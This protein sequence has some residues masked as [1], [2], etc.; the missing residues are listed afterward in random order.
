MLGVLRRV[1][2]RKQ[3]LG[4]SDFLVGCVCNTHR[5][6]PFSHFLHCHHCHTTMKV[7]HHNAPAAAAVT[8]SSCGLLP[9]R[10]WRIVAPSSQQ[11]HDGTSSKARNCCVSTAHYVGVMHHAAIRARRRQSISTT[12]ATLAAASFPAD[13]WS[14]CSGISLLAYTPAIRGVV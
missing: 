14:T 10:R 4:R 2:P 5:S 8:L 12:N 1:L 6:P 11:L 7:L 3:R 9:N 13:D